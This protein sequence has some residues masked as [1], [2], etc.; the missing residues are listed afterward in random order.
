[1]CS[2]QHDHKL[3]TK[4]DQKKRKYRYLAKRY[5]WDVCAISY[6][7]I[8][9]AEFQLSCI[10]ILNKFFSSLIKSNEG[11]FAWLQK[12]YVQGPSI[13]L[14]CSFRKITWIPIMKRSESILC[15]LAVGS[16]QKKVMW[17]HAFVS[18]NL[19]GTYIKSLS[20]EADMWIK[21]RYDDGCIT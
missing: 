9:P 14:K 19:S 3:G 16:L 7:S 4:Y 17:K 2:F 5:S 13:Y 6:S 15:L 10:A 21:I 12:K 20:S 8:T 11:L 18:C 1:M